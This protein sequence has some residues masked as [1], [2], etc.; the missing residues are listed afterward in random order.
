MGISIKDNI[1]REA[2]PPAPKFEKEI[3]YL[4]TAI[5]QVPG[6]RKIASLFQQTKH[7][8]NGN[9]TAFN[10][11]LREDELLRSVPE[12]FRT[13]EELMGRAYLKPET[14]ELVIVFVLDHP[15][16]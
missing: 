15:M 1:P 8:D 16:T 11:L 4:E 10:R 12:Q 6:A 5:E 2:I 3:D 13:A 7:Y 14:G 9:L